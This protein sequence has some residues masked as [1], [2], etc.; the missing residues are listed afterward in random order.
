VAKSAQLMQVASTDRCTI[1]LLGH[2]LAV[3]M[4]DAVRKS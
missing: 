2:G 3:T 1:H 4:M